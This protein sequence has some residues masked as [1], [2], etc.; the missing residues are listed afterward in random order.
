MFYFACLFYV[1]EPVAQRPSNAHTKTIQRLQKDYPK[2]T[3]RLPNDHPTTT[4]RLPNDYKKTI[5]RPSNDYAKTLLGDRPE[6]TK[7]LPIALTGSLS[8]FNSQNKKS[9]SYTQTNLLK[10]CLRKERDSNPRTLAGQRFSRPPRSTTPPSFLCFSSVLSLFL[11]C[12][13][14][15]SPLFLLCSFGVAS[16][17]VRE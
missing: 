4:Q 14:P 6:Y 8:F 9:V 7:R 5:Q 17:V 16:G 2:T 11:P 15:I 12:I 10:N 3:Q 1:D 13:S